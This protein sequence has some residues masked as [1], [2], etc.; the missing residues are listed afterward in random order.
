MQQKRRKKPKRD[1][2]ASLSTSILSD[3]QAEEV[4]KDANVRVPAN[5]DVDDLYNTS[6][7]QALAS[8]D[9]MYDAFEDREL[10][11]K[12][13]ESQEQ[14]MLRLL[15]SALSG[16]EVRIILEIIHIYITYIYMYIYIY[17][18]YIYICIYINVVV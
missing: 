4:A 8:S 17:I 5:E 14:A 13:A 18:L 7:E 16:R 6:V 1:R 3:W 15:G 11:V 10:A 9:A 12:G 2:K